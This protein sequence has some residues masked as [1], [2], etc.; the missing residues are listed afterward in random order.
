MSESLQSHISP[1]MDRF[2]EGLR[3]VLS[4]SKASLNQMLADE[5]KIKEGKLKPGPKPKTSPSVSDRA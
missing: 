3:K 4:V 5:K 2:H 1:E